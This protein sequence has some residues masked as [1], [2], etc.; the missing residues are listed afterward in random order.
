[1]MRFRLASLALLL[2]YGSLLLASTPSAGARPPERER[3]WAVTLAPAPGDLSLVEIDFF[4][5][6]RQLISTNSLRVA[7]RGAFGTGYLA[8]AALRSNK[9]G[10]AR[11]LVLLV[12]RPTSAADTT[13]I[14]LRLTARRALGEAEL[15]LLTNPLTDPVSGLRPALCN[16]RL[17]GGALNGSQLRTLGSRGTSLA[18]FDAASAVAAAYNLACGLPHTSLFEQA[19]GHRCASG[20]LAQG[21]L[22]CPAN[23]VCAPAPTQPSAPTA[24]G[25]PTAPAPPKTPGC[26]PC[27]PPPG[28]ACPLAARTSICASPARRRPVEAH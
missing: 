23:A 6:R 7:A 22:C 25:E 18:G 1:M 21:T 8:A 26:A 16:L 24:P 5:S 28:S 3:L 13:G 11:A 10:D 4:H 20:A 19:I 15:W 14:H 9:R 12:N 17:H 2:A 27:N